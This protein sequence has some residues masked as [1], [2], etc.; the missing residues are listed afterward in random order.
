[1]KI[2]DIFEEIKYYR[3]NDTGIIFKIEKIDTRVFL[4]QKIDTEY[5]GYA[6]VLKARGS[7]EEEVLE[8][9]KSLKYNIE[10]IEYE[11]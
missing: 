5:E 6:W 2:D 10:E 9:I 11:E 8:H 4:R 3:C 7:S 1:M